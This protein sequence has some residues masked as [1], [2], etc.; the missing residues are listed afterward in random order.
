LSLDT[1]SCAAHQ[2][3]LKV[4][5]CWN[6]ITPIC[7]C[8]PRARTHA[9]SARTK[10]C[11]QTKSSLPC[12]IASA[13]RCMDGGQGAPVALRKSQS[14]QVYACW[15]AASTR[16]SESLKYLWSLSV[17]VRQLLLPD[18]MPA[19]S[20]VI[21]TSMFPRDGSFCFRVDFY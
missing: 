12:Y 15:H 7:R 1:F 17:T 8:D 10:S 3:C 11:T 5:Y 2:R 4:T 14:N 9:P 21:R 19:A 16:T 18:S 13:C 20:Q 6:T